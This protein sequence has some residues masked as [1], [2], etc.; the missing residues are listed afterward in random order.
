LD[1]IF[2][3]QDTGTFRDHEVNQNFNAILKAAEGERKDLFL[4]TASHFNTNAQY[5][6]KDFWVC[7]VLNA[8][9]HNLPQKSPRLVFRGGT[10]LSKSFGLINR[11]SEDIDITVF[12][13]DIG[14]PMSNEDIALLS[15]TKRRKEL[16]AIKQDCARY[17]SNDLRSHLEGLAAIELPDADFKIEPDPDDGQTLLFWYPRSLT[18]ED[19]NYVRPTVKIESGAKSATH[20]CTITS[21]QPYVAQLV[22]NMNLI[23]NGINTIKPERTFWDKVIILHGL[24]QWF[25]RKNE[26]RHAGKR[27]SRHYY[28]I[29]LLERS[30]A[31]FQ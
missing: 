28:D 4:A 13:Q 17:V 11:F 3:K 2:V 1:A 15:G 6:E 18:Y 26:L 14:H 10:S 22:P 27:V 31:V 12:R 29:I 30:R 19:D 5:V 9:F 21:V 20:P 24:R 25:E 7:W 23:V 8:L 16:D